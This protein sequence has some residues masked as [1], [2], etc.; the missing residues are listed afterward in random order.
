MV[1]A[2]RCAGRGRK[3]ASRPSAGPPSNFVDPHFAGERVAMNTERVGRLGEAAVAAAE[4]P[5]DEAL[6]ELPDGVLEL[7]ALVDHFFDESIESITDHD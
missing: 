1:A 5:A 3:R 2:D 6:L 4:H 7:D